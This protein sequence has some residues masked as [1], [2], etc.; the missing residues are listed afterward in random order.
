MTRLAPI[1]M[2]SL[3]VAC[4][5][6]GPSSVHVSRDVVYAPDVAFHAGFWREEI[7]K[8]YPDAVVVFAHGTDFGDRWYV[9][10][11]E[12][13]VAPVEQVVIRLRRTYPTSRIVLI[14]CNP[15]GYTLDAPGV[16]Y[17][18]DNVWVS[19]DQVVGSLNILRDR[20]HD[21]VGSFDEFVHNPAQ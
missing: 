18:K 5:M 20:M 14:V 7:N 2:L 11:D 8:V 19:P 16:S 6:P 17:A 12:G 4:S 13:S 3:V 9:W 15:G 1:L 21:Y 10:I